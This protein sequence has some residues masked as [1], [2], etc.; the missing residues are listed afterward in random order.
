MSRT[1]IFLSALVGSKRFSG[2]RTVPFSGAPLSAC[3]MEEMVRQQAHD[4][5]FTASEGARSSPLKLSLQS[6]K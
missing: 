2:C 6:F 1:V 5:V 3:P 4:D